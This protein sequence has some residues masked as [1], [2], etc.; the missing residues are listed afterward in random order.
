MASQVV[1]NNKQSTYS[2]PYGFYTVTLTPSNRTANSVTIK[3]DVSAHLQYDDSYAGF[4]VTAGIMLGGVWY[5]FTLAG[6][7]TL[8]DGTAWIGTDPIYASKTITLSG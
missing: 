7:G 3:C 5:D 4:G 8:S 2:G 6:K 1:L